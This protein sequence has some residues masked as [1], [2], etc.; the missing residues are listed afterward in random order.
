[1]QSLPWKTVRHEFAFDGAWRDIFV[2][3]TDIDG[4]QRMLDGLRSSH[5]D[6][7]Y[8]RNSEPMEL[9]E[10]AE[11]AFSPNGEDRPLLS[12]RFCG[13]LANS[14]FFTP[15]EIEFD[16]DP[17]EVRGQER[18]DGVFAFMHTLADFV[19]HEVILCPENCPGVVIFRV[20][21]GAAKVEHVL[22]EKHLE[23]S[24]WRG[25]RLGALCQ[26]AKRRALAMLAALRARRPS[27]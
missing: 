6:I 1:M 19:G 17:R 22:A 5:Q 21:P 24:F 13:V 16:I 25:T 27:Q 7:S 26:K 20:R 14:H 11:D 15:E 10:N 23:R 18:L 12:V 8:F 9:P 3:G 2:L 4:W